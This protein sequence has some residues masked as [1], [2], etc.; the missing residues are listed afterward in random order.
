MRVALSNGRGVDRPAA[1]GYRSCAMR[2]DRAW[3]DDCWTRSKSRASP[4][5]VS[6]VV[7]E[8]D[9]GDPIELWEALVARGVL[10]MDWNDGSTRRYGA[11]QREF[12]G[13]TNLVERTRIDEH[14]IVRS[15]NA[16]RDRTLARWLASDPARTLE[17]E[18]LAIEAARS[19]SLALTGRACAASRVLWTTKRLPCWMP[20]NGR[21]LRLHEISRPLYGDSPQAVSGLDPAVLAAV[22]SR[23]TSA[24]RRALFAQIDAL[25]AESWMGETLQSLLKHAVAW[26]LFC[27]AIEPFVADGEPLRWTIEPFVGLSPKP[28]SLSRQQLVDPLVWTIELYLR[29]VV[30]LEWG[31]EWVLAAPLV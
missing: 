17:C 10:P 8:L 29:W 5:L 14:H 9:R 31:D 12:I 2:L 28:V 15:S 19:C 23:S 6:D 22:R 30:V 1:R 20:Y 16:P 25:I 27:E 13:S 18:R 21:V 7:A 24:R 4:Y 3:I 11:S 26:A